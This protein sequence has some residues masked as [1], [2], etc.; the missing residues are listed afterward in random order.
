ME[1]GEI[2]GL[3]TAVA[4]GIGLAATAGLR[5]WLPLLLAGGLARLGVLE[6]GEAFGFVSSTPALV[7]F[8]VAT[9]AEIVADKVPAI[10]HAL[11][12]I[13]TVVRPAA[14]A[15]LA[16]SALYQVKDPLVALVI[17]LCVGA[18][19]ALGPHA[20]KSALRA[21]S[22]AT[23]AGIANPLVS[24]VEDALAIG[25]FI[26]VVILPVISVAVLATV[27]WLLVRRRRKAAPAAA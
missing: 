10:D 14:G 11:D 9:I 19:V 24:F 12:V 5:A 20:A 17:G 6:L 15:L 16:A 13:S 1:L 18:P 22:S 25:L 7:L 27:I 2:W 3:V 26:A 4:L 23:T 21:A 8:G